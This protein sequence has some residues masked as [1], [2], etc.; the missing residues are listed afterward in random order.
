MFARAPSFHKVNN[1]HC[2][3]TINGVLCTQIKTTLKGLT[4]IKRT[5]GTEMLIKL[6]IA[7]N[8][9]NLPDKYKEK[10]TT[11]VVVQNLGIFTAIVSGEQ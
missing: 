3:S 7:Q 11:S 4:P 5:A 6:F 8:V 9:D 2:P 1:G 10:E